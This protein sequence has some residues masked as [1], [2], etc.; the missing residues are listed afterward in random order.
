LVVWGEGV[1]FFSL[2]ES[3]VWGTFPILGTFSAKMAEISV[4][5]GLLGRNVWKSVAF[6]ATIGDSELCRPGEAGSALKAA[7]SSGCCGEFSGVFALD[8]SG[9]LF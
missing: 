5:G 2:S 8:E 4:A 9:C 6:P 3:R 1:H 7:T